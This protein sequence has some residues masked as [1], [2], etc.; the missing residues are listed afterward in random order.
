[1]L[2]DHSKEPQIRNSDNVNDDA[3]EISNKKSRNVVIIG[4]SMLNNINGKGLS[5]SKKVDVL[6]IPGA[7]SANIVDKIDDVLQGKPESSIV[8]VGTNDQ[9]NN[10]YLLSNVKK[11]VNKVKNTSPDTVLSFSNIKGDKRNLE[12]MRADTNSRLKNFCNQKNIHLILKDNIKEEHLGIKKLHLNRKNN[13]IFA[14]N[15]LNVI[16]GN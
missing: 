1:M 6:N 7:T 5:K 9:T 11:I 14:K 3:V 16:E 15:L 8:H 13:S 12:K 10:V 2:L 4:D